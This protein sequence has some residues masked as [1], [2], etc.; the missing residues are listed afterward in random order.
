MG[1]IKDSE[2]Y[3]GLHELFLKYKKFSFDVLA[4]VPYSQ[5]PAWIAFSDGRVEEALKEK[6]GIAE[7]IKDAYALTALGII[8]SL[9]GFWYMWL[10][11]GAIML[12]LLGI[13]G[14]VG[15]LASPLWTIAVF[16]ALIICILVWPGAVNLAR[17]A[18]YHIVMKLFGG[19]GSY[20]D[21]LRVMVLSTAAH[22]AL[23]IPIFAAYAVIVGFILGPLAYVITIYA[24]YLQ[25]RGM[26]HVHGMEPKY[27]A[28]ATIVALVLE[29]GA[30]MTIYFA[31]YLAMMLLS[32]SYS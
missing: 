25:Y 32:M 27:A 9:I 3:S 20:S 29:I 13:L 10:F 19:K 2:A 26:K 30:Y 14:F 6:R 12:F 11:F 4:K 7:S 5:V 23:M 22:L 8:A 15:I 31:S 16:A 17:A 21:T 1:E 28:I 18:F 24:L